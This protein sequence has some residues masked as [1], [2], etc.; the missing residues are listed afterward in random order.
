MYVM[1]HLLQLPVFCLPQ[2][3]VCKLALLLDF[4]TKIC[5]VCGQFVTL[6][7]RTVTNKDTF[8]PYHLI[9]RVGIGALT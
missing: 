4:P 9:C 5:I 2:L 1:K 3:M 6:T 7:L 8:L